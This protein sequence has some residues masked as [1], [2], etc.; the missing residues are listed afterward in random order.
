MRSDTN[1]EEQKKLHAA[2]ERYRVADRNYWNVMRR[3]RSAREAGDISPSLNT[4]WEEA[5]DEIKDA[6]AE[7]QDILRG[8]P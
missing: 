8:N 5:C 6:L 3:Y 1:I 4:E 2:D 7:I